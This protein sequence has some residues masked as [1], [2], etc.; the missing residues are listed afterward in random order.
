MAT[1]PF[2]TA[3]LTAKLLFAG[4]V[5]TTSGTGNEIYLVPGSRCAKLQTFTL[6]NT[7]G[8]AVTVDVYI[9]P[10]ADVPGD[11]HKIVHSF[12]LPAGDTQNLTSYV[13]GL[14]LGEDDAVWVRA[15]TGSVVN[16][17]LTGVEGA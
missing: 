2:N 14:M 8:V 5:T 3:T 11:Q 13:G 9:V 1:V 10:T 17:V 6:C 16:A 4:R 12:S 7:S 15:S